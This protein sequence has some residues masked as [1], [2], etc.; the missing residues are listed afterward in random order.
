MKKQ[1]L[2]KLIFTSI[3][4]AVFIIAG[5]AFSVEEEQDKPNILT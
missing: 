2:V 1:I 5:F 3:I 4:A